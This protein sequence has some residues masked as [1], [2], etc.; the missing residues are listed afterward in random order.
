MATEA[1]RYRVEENKPWGT[2]AVV[3]LWPGGTV[4]SPF[5]TRQEAISREEDIATY[6]GDKLELV[7]V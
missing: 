5:P 7:E 1:K 6:F 2:W 4:R 3:E